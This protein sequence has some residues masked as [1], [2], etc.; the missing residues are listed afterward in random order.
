MTNNFEKKHNATIRLI[1]LANKASPSPLLGQA[2]GP[3]GINI[4]EFCKNFNNQTKNIKGNI[5][6][7]TKI[8]FYTRENYQIIIKTPTTT[9]LVKNIANIVKG[10]P[11]TKKALHEKQGFINLKEIYH[12]AVF[13]KC[14]RELNHLNI[15]SLCKTLIGSIKSIGILIKNLN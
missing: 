10:N 4:M 11:L 12:L 5:Y 13:K 3:Y 15:K 2:L 6:I 1:L 9:F 7:P 14:D 8:N